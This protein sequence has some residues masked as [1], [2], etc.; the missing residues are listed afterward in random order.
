[1]DLAAAAGLPQWPE[2]L[3]LISLRF[4]SHTAPMAPGSPLAIRFPVPTRILALLPS[5]IAIN[6]AIGSLVAVL[7][8]PV[9]LD[10]IGTILVAVLAGPLWGIAAGVLGQVV[11]SL[12]AGYQWLPFAAI[13]VLIALMAALAGRRGGFAGP[14]RTMGWGLLTGLVGGAASAVISFWV[15][16]GV[17]ATGVTAVTTLLV[18]FGLPLATA[19]TVSSLGTDLLDK[20]VAFALVG[21]LL[22]SLPGRMMHR[23]PGAM[24]AIAR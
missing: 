4:C 23:F 12:Y 6:L 7:G 1:M 8:L 9:Y 2:S 24:S 3:R 20:A 19:V 17:T 14:V 16:R 13:Q 5:A 15:F 11:F 18:K 21:M 10:S 22:R